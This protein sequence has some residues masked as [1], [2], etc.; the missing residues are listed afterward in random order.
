ML[1]FEPAS[2]RTSGTQYL[3]VNQM[4]IVIRCAMKLVVM[5]AALSL[6]GVQNAVQYTIEMT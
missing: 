6:L 1:H 2:V 4:I 5:C 3:S